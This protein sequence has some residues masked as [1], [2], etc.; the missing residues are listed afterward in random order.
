MD[1]E[2]INWLDFV[3]AG[4]Y[5]VDEVKERCKIENAEYIVMKIVRDFGYRR[6]DAHTPNPSTEYRL[7]E[8]LYDELDDL[9]QCEDC[10]NGCQLMQ[11]SDGTYYFQ[12]SGQNFYDKENEYAGTNTVKVYFKKFKW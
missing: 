7:T 10:K 9:C 5:I 12:I 1:K 4:D 2:I 11:E 6:N 3:V 8:Y